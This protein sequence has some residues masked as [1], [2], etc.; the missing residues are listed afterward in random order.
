MS[1]KK[2]YLGKKINKELIPILVADGHLINADIYKVTC[3]IA[4]IEEEIEVFVADPE[5]Y[6]EQEEPEIT[7]VKPLLG[8][9]ILERY[10]VLFKGSE[11]K[12]L[13]FHP[14]R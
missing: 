2:A 7:T 13:L 10:D 3:E 5:K 9:G 11:R 12:I 14:D 8:R 6:F 1:K 4:G